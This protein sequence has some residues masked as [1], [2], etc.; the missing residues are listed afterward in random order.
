MHRIAVALQPEGLAQEI[1]IIVS[2][3]DDQMVMCFVS[4]GHD[5]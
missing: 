2:F 1:A 4:G 3:K 5:V